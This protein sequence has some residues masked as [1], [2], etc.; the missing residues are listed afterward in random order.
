[1]GGLGNQMFQYAFYL[2]MKQVA[3]RVKVDIS[4]FADYG[5]HNGFELED[6]FPSI[7]LKKT[8]RTDLNLY[9]NNNRE[10]IWR[11]LRRL[12]G[13]KNVYWEESPQF[14]YHENVFHDKRGR[15]YWGYWQHISYINPV[16]KE[17]RE[18]LIFP[19]ISDQNNLDLLKKIQLSPPA[20]SVHVR[21]GDYLQVPLLGGIC[22]EEYYKTSIQFMKD[23]FESP[24]FVI[25]SND[26]AW[27]RKEFK[28]LNAIF[29]DWNT[30]KNSFRDMQMMSLCD[31]QIIANSSFSWWAAW[32]NQNPSQIVVSPKRWVN[33]PKLD[34][35][36]L[37][38]P[39]FVTF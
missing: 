36:G 19:E 13:S 21:R 35:S 14:A 24:L 17:V 12:N 25:F 20:I 23:Q 7:A 31:H 3:G 29:V 32:L 22:T 33:D 9:T 38:L 39:H 34:T 26:M 28:D 8:S 18:Q 2:R 15:Y 30:G 10:W 1:M 27:C 16:E 6:V 11:K 4:D 5:L 37:I